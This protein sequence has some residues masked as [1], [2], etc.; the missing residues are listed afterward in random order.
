MHGLLSSQV[1]A[2]PPPHTQQTPHTHPSLRVGLVVRG[3]GQCVT[4]ND[5]TPLEPGRVFIIRADGLHCFHTNTSELLI[6]AYHPDSDFGPTDT[7]HPMIN[8]TILERGLS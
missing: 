6:V 7:L 2:A 3:A 5:R 8:R 4:P 1:T